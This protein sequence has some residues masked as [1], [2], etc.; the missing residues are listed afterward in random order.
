M[1]YLDEWEQSVKERPGDF[2]KTQRNM[3]M[4]S[5]QTRLGLKVT[6]KIPTLHSAI[7]QQLI[8][9]GKSFI[10]LVKY[11]FTID[12]VKSFLSQRLCQDPLENFFGVQRQGGG[13]HDNPSVKQFMENTQALRVV[14]MIGFSGVKRGNCR[15]GA[16]E[17]EVKENSATLPKRARK[18][19]KP[20]GLY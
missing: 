15:G 4:L 20:L 6:C 7:Y 9:T 17:E 2:T 11:I 3:M 19:S 1:G 13:V 12:G 14:K 18:P 8:A 10:Q 5:P 16:K